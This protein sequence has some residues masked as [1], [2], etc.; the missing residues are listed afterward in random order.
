MKGADTIGPSTGKRLRARRRLHLLAGLNSSAAIVLM[1]ILV[2]MVNYLSSRNYVRHDL[3]RERFYALSE[4]TRALLASLDDRV[5]ITVFIQPGH[6]IYLHAYD[7]LVQLLREYEYASDNRI[8]VERI[9]PDR[10]LARAEALMT[11]LN[12]PGPNVVVL[13]QG[14]RHK[15]IHAE[16]LM[17]MDYQPLLRGGSP[18]KL[19][20]RG[21]TAISSALLAITQTE[22]PRVYFLEGH[23]ERDFN[24][25]DDYVGLSSMGE[26]IRRDDIELEPFSFARQNNLPDD[27]SALII[28]GPTRRYSDGELERIRA[29]LE[30]AG[31]LILMLNSETDAGFAPLLDQWGIESLDSLVVDPARTLSGFDLLV[32]QY[33]THPVSDPLAGITT[34]FYWPRAL[35]LKA[36]DAARPRAADEPKPTA[37]AL[38][39]P[40]AWAETDLERQPHA[41]DAA[42][43]RSGPVPVAVAV[44]RGPLA[45]AAV[46]IPP[47]RVVVFGD[48]DF[49][50]NA[51]VSGGN[52]DLFMNALNWVL[53]RDN[54]MAISP[55]PV[56]E[57]RLMISRNRLAA[58]FWI[59]VGALPALAATTGL[60]VWWR[61]RR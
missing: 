2:I 20:F 18:R 31:R 5:R 47:M 1:L 6:E 7:D 34:V 9:D 58:L 45:S 33:G 29:Y 42:R 19:T 13:E 59:V 38:S 48:V 10:N 25:R 55:R 12:L 50:S 46:E 17:E 11:R 43:D 57:A 15:I 24:E 3:S 44:E 60:V 8:V 4:K 30:R 36:G 35:P 54:L 56:S 37:L 49:I 51:G 40:A 22:R 28:A 52:G 26:E 32:D 21:E 14:E 23:G 41:F 53:E 61:R 16:Q 39:S 27:A